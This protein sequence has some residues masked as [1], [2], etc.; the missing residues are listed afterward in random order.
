M[1]T[2]HPIRVIVVDDG[3]SARE[4]IRFKTEDV[5]NE[6]GDAPGTRVETLLPEFNE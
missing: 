5:A 6:N 2:S 1:A 3:K 4:N